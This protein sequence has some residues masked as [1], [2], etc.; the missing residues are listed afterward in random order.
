MSAI[1]AHALPFSPPT[2][3][4]S[5]ASLNRCSSFATDSH[6]VSASPSDAHADHVPMDE[7]VPTIEHVEEA[8]TTSTAPPPCH[9]TRLVPPTIAPCENRHPMTTRAKNGIFKPKACV[10]SLEP[11]TVQQALANPKWQKAMNEEFQALMKNIT[12][13][14]VEPPADRLPIGSKWVFSVKYNPDGSIN[15]YKA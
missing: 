13:T 12:R 1:Y 5:V 4:P 6:V 7:F 14:L 2:I 8:S 3:F 15:K 10:V 9:K 11:R